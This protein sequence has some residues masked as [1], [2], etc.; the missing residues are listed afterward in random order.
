MYGLEWYGLGLKAS[1]C[2]NRLAG[3]PCP[4]PAV[5]QPGCS[6]KPGR[7]IAGRAAWFGADTNQLSSG[8]MFFLTAGPSLQQAP[9]AGILLFFEAGA[10]AEAPNGDLPA[11]SFNVLAQ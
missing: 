5:F 3:E 9:E 1:G 8:A 10:P 2:A 4:A 11:K 6:K 7:W